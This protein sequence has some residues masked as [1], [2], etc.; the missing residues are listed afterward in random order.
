ML[1][2][3]YTLLNF[4]FIII[5]IIH[6]ISV[7]LKITWII[8][9]IIFSNGFSRSII[10]FLKNFSQHIMMKCLRLEKDKLT[11]EENIIMKL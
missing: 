7:L 5:Y 8:L 11:I 4:N 3:F 1:Q 10:D 2:E 9:K 6:K